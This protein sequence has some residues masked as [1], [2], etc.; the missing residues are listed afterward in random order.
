MWATRIF[1]TLA[2][3]L[4]LLLNDESYSADKYCTA[5]L[6]YTNSS[7]LYMIKHDC[8]GQRCISFVDQNE[9]FV[10]KQNV[11]YQALYRT[12][13]H[14]YEKGFVSV[15]IR[16][17]KKSKDKLAGIPDVKIRRPRFEFACFGRE[18]N[19]TKEPLPEFKD[20]ESPSV[21][22]EEYDRYHRFGDL[23]SEELEYLNENFH[24][25][26]YDGKK[27]VSSRELRRRVQFLM[28]D[29]EDY[30]MGFARLFRAFGFYIDK[31][32]GDDYQ[33]V[34]GDMSKAELSSKYGALEARLL[35][36]DKKTRE[37]YP[38]CVSFSIETQA[39]AVDIGIVD[40][41]LK[42]NPSFGRNSA[43]LDTWS[44]V[45]R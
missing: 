19:V 40:L 37:P 2:I 29:R 4:I 34:S 26:Y 16:H 3:S 1:F 18:K 25:R 41:E 12:T 36:Y 17:I 24:V 27:C 11:H 8:N 43:E 44:V 6:K 23:N 45:R 9:P 28:H 5:F 21:K 20:G 7:G 32:Y 13:Q 10:M 35:A 30:P 31:A 14:T 38:G 33:R 39:A 42:A 22:Y 15:H